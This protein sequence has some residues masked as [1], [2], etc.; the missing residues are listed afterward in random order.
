MHPTGS[1]NVIDKMAQAILHDTMARASLPP[2]FVPSSLSEIVVLSDFWS[3]DRRGARDPCRPVVD[4]RARHAGAGGRSGRGD[5]SLFRPHRLRRTGRLRHD[6]RGP[7]R[8]LGGRLHR[9]RRRAIARKFAPRPAV[10]AGCSRSTTPTARHAE[11]LLFLHGGMT[12]NKG[13][14][15][16]RRCMIAGLPFAF[17][18]PLMLIGLVSL[19]V[20]WWLLRLMPPRPRR[21]DF[22]PTRLLFD[23]APKEETPARTPWW[24]TLIR[25]LAAALVIFAA[26][27]P[28]YNP[29]EGATRSTAPLVMLIDDGWS[30]AASWE[31]RIKSADELIASAESDSRGVALIPL[32][33]P[34]RDI[35]L[36]PAGNARIALRQLSPKPY[37][38]ER[39]DMLPAITRFLSATGDAEV[40]WIADGVDTGRGAEFVAGLPAAI[41]DRAL[42]IYD[43]GIAPAHALTAAENAAARM[44]VK[45]LR[46][47]TGAPEAGA[48]ARA[49]RQGIAGRRC[50]FHL[51]R[52]GHRDRSRIRPAGRVAQRHHPAGSRRR[53]L[54]RRGAAARQALAPPRRRCRHRRDRRHG[55]AAAGV[56]VLS[57]ARA[58]AFRRRAA[59]RTRRA[60]D[61][62]RALPRSETADD[63]AGGRRHAGG[64][65]SASGSMS[66]SRKAACWSASL[67]RGLRR[68]TTIWSRCACA[69]AGAASAAR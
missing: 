68:P 67:A 2:A 7:R 49:G 63:R 20:L 44:V 62:H 32:S 38:V 27:G 45:V 28:I 64:P 16:G 42:T 43:N 61:R 58:G 31:T 34:A 19:P 33:E 11:L 51:Q 41:G 13:G 22:P 1:R 55:A 24:L 50:P 8:D 54:G 59:R 47:G 40:I 69:A 9:A 17:A 48:G 60:G 4:R 25:L 37:A 10:S 18:Q 5:V 29:I 57:V 52:A 15:I 46:A 65:T 53:A 6:H 35:T 12:V 26:A 39:V 3:P 36:M 23:I 66:G 30:A 14:K 56:D 21:I